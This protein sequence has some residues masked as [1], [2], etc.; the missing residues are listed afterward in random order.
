MPMSPKKTM[1]TTSG[2]SMFSSDL[3]DECLAAGQKVEG[4]E[5]QGNEESESDSGDEDDMDYDK[6]PSA[7][8]LLSICKKKT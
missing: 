5:A 8:L 2:L 4:V 1:T 3:V 6:L 7:E